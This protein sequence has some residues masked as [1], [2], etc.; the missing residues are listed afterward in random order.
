MVL[1]D[2]LAV[3]SAMFVFGLCAV[4]LAVR[5][6]YALVREARRQ[7]ALVTPAP[8]HVASDLSSSFA[9]SATRWTELD[10]VQFARYAS[11]MRLD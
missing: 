11:Q 1:A 10:E 8:D 3:N 7:A 9:T 4:A 2:G 6:G 5:L